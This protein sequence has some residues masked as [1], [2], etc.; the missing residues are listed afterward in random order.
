[1]KYSVL[2]LLV[3]LSVTLQS[4]LSSDHCPSVCKLFLI[5]YTQPNLL[6]M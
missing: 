6:S 2:D 4:K 1:M 3:H 5:K